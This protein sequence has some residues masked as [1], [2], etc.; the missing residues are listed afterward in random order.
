[1]FTDDT[2]ATQVLHG[3]YD[4]LKPN[5]IRQKYGLDDKRFAAAKKRIRLKIMSQRTDGSEGDNHG[6]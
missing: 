5:E 4:G 3:W 2:E 6:I 1:M